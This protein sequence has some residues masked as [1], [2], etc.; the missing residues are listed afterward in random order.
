MSIKTELKRSL[1]TVLQNDHQGSFASRADRRQILM[2]LADDLIGLGYKI[3]HIQQFK[4]KHVTA[5]TQHWQQKGLNNGTIKNRLAVVRHL[6]RML[7]NSHLIPDNSILKVG[8]RKY[9]SLENRAVH[10]PELSRLADPY[11]RVSAELQRVFGLRREESLKIRP[12]LA[13]KGDKLS[14]L[15]AWCKGNR[16]REIPIRTEEQR[17][18]LEQA[19]L[20][21]RRQH[22]LIPEEKTYIQ[23]RY[24]YEKQLR[25]LKL[26]SHALRHAYAQR[27]YQ[28]LT[29]WLP[30]IAGGPVPRDY[31]PE[32]R[33]QD[34]LARLTLSEE[35]GHSRIRV[36]RSYC[37]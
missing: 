14:L 10:Q 33:Y 24:V 12:A 15:G 37:G 31:T 36:M 6:S 3:P 23:H 28:E 27:R 13:D 18:W 5:L 35:L 29:G 2:Q 8:S 1:Y 4:S 16:S 25:K 20:L 26:R 22:S 21:A 34:T 32:Q 11:V 30:P 7:N 17:Y 9:Y 19:K